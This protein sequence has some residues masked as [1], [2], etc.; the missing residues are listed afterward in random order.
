ME[1][2]YGDEECGEDP[3]DLCEDCKQEFAEMLAEARMDLD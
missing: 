3:Q 1:C 2:P